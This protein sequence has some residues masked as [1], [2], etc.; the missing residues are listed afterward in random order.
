MP[1]VVK[2]VV[3]CVAEVNEEADGVAEVD[4]DVV[5]VGNGG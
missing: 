3:D 1:C 5:N 2:E 4:V